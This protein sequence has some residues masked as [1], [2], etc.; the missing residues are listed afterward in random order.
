M[1]KVG[2]IYYFIYIMI[3]FIYFLILYLLLR[4]KSKEIQKKVLTIVLFTNLLI[5]FTKL[6]FYPY[7]MGLPGSIRKIT[8]ENICAG[9]TL[10]FPFI[11]ISKNKILKDYMYYFGIFGGLGALLYPTEAFGKEAFSYDV[12]RF[13]LCHMTL[14]IVPL[15]AA[16][17]NHHRPNYKNIWQTVLVFMVV[18]LIIL[19]N[20]IML[21]EIGFVKKDPVYYF[22]IIGRNSSFIFGPNQ[23]LGNITK[24]V[25]ILVPSFMIINGL[26]IPIIWMI[27]PLWIYIPIIC[28][29]VSLPWNI[30][31]IKNDLVQYKA[32]R[33]SKI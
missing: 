21:I 31:N 1:V 26:Y 6:A 25:T 20:E 17:F 10:I 29:I 7:N 2:N 12:I 27:I 19:I 4:N 13:Y 8:F 14:V 5:H 9:S 28:F 3:A 18:E 32:K 24:I 22:D 11:Y 23:Y 30:N 33:R 16:V 15:L